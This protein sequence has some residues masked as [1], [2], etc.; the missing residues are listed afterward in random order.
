MPPRFSTETLQQTT[1][2]I[3]RRFGIRDEYALRLASLAL[4]GIESHGSNPNDM[5][6][7]LRTIES[8]VASWVNTGTIESRHL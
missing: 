5:D 3:K 7:I 2:F 8:V 6:A 4:N 1:D